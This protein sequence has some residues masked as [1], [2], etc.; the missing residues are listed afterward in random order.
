MNCFR[1]FT[2]S[3][4]QVFSGNLL[5][6]A[7]LVFYIAWWTVCFRPGG[8]ENTAGAGI[9]IVVALFIGVAA[10]IT[11]FVGINSLSQTGKGFPFMYILLGSVAFYIILLAVT[12]N[13]FHRPVTS[14]LLLII[15]WAALEWSAIAV[16]QGCGRLSTGAALALVIL[17]ALATVTGIVCYILHFSLNEISRFW[18]GLI[19]LIVDAGV[20][21]VF[22]AVLALSYNDM[23]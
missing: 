7:T 17:V 11:L 23:T 1:D 16:L 14:E 6:F 19:P 15:V 21:A 18:N 10:I 3:L 9:F 13:V 5:M 2:V 22:L 20:V 8:N 12:K 4:W